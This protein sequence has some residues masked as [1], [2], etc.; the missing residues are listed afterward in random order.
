MPDHIAHRVAHPDG[1]GPRPKRRRP[2]RPLPLV[3]PVPDER[4]AE[5]MDDE[6]AA[7][8]L[9]SELLALVEA[10]RI[11][12]V[13]QDGVIRYAAIDPDADT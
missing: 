2:P 5:A 12:L 6:R 10:G 11:E 3:D 7:E 1:P 8:Q 4:T 9:I 13:E